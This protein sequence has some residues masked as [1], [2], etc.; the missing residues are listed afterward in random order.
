MTAERGRLR[1][2]RVWEDLDHGRGAWYYG[3]E[4]DLG[5]SG[6][7]RAAADDPIFGRTAFEG[8]LS[9]A[10]ESVHVIPHDGRRRR[11]TCSATIS[12]YT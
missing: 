3:S 9:R 4:I 8:T 10:E 6:Y 5:Y 12:G 11:F 2:S 1:A 7:L